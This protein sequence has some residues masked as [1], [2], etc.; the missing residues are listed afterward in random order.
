MASAYNVDPGHLH[1]QVDAGQQRAADALLV[2]GEGGG[3]ADALFDR[4]AVEA[5]GATVQSQYTNVLNKCL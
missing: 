5:T 1:E 2:P 4:V 3:R